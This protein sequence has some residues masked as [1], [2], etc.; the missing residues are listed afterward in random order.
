MNIAASVS[1]AEGEGLTGL[2]RQN[3][4]CSSTRAFANS[5]SD[6]NS[7]KWFISITT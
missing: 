7:G 1:E 6:A 2:G 3:T 4:F 5:T